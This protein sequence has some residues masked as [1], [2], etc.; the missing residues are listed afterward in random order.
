M[1]SWLVLVDRFSGY[2][3]A[4][5]LTKTDSASIIRQLR[6][7][8]LAFGFPTTIRSDGGP[9]FRTEFTTFCQQ[10]NIKHELSSPYNSQSNG[11]AEAAVKSVK[12]L[13]S[14]CKETKE[15]FEVALSAWRNTPRADGFS[16]AQMFFGRRQRT[17]TLPTLP[18]HHQHVDLQ[19]ANVASHDQ[20][21]AKVEYHDQHA[22][23]LP[24]LGP[25]N[26]VARPKPVQ[27]EMGH[28]LRHQVHA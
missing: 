11:L 19:T 4:A 18:V 13:L 21:Q 15:D 7:W 17:S 25:G 22:V 20:L 8:F 9:Q 12:T 5:R 1:V 2:T 26:P 24:P 27:S 16:P 6:S 14:K 23:T 10:N 3:W 28:L